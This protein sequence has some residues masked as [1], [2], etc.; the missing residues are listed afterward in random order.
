MFLMDRIVDKKKEK[1]RILYHVK[2]EGYDEL[3]WEP[4]TKLLQDGKLQFIKDFE[5][6]KK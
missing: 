1:N 4:R 3:S 5:K 6:I 2:W